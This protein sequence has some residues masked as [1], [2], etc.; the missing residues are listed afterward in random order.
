MKNKKNIENSMTSENAMSLEDEM[1]QSFDLFNFSSFIASN[2]KAY[3]I[4]DMDGTLIDSM[5]Y[6]DNLAE[7]YLR[8]KGVTG[9]I[10]EV[11][12]T[13]QTMTMS[14][15]ANLFANKF[16]INLTPEQ[17][18]DEMNQMM[19]NHYINDIPLKPL[20]LDLLKTLKSEGKHLCVASTTAK[21]L[22]EAC[23]KRL[24]I[25]SMFDFVLSCEDY[26]TSKREP[27]IYF[28]ATKIFKT[29]QNNITVFEDALYAIQTA[30]SSDFNVI[31]VYDD[32]TK[33]DWNQICEI[34]GFGIKLE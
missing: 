17:I 8:E 12:K 19:N 10:S 28:E 18:M 33:N 7:E 31:A 24:R 3:A 15:S 16:S 5:K 34:S 1:E 11:I 32:S 6:W 21:P 27:K 9:D 2:V 14:E 4:F 25:F 30:K 13:V 26:D 29:T 23:L 22:I 20:A